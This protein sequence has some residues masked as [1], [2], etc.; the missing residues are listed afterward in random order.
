MCGNAA[1]WFEI[2]AFVIL[3]VLDSVGF[4]YLIPVIAQISFSVIPQFPDLVNRHIPNYVCKE[5]LI[6]GKL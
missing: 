1:I 3:L 5:A 4:T 2:K 6:E